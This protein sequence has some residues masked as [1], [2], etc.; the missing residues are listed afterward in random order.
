M[1]DSGLS[2]TEVI[3]ELRTIIRRE[4][5]HPRLAIALADTEYRM[6]HANSEFIQMGALTTAIQEIFS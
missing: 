5:N 2:G 1:I 4:Y 3:M 6:R